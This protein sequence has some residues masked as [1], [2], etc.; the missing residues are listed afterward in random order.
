MKIRNQNTA[1]QFLY[2][3][4][5]MEGHYDPPGIEFDDGVARVKKDVGEELVDSSDYP[6]IRAEQDSEPE[7]VIEEIDE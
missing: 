7:T 3:A 1:T 4:E 6:T 5:I 2:D